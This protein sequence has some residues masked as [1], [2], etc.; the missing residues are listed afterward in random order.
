RRRAPELER[1]Y[2]IWLYPVPALLALVGWLFVFVTN[3]KKPLL[4][5]GGTLAVGLICFLIWSR[6]TRRWPFAAEER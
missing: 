2:R 6:W 1:P 5:G 4:V 3:E